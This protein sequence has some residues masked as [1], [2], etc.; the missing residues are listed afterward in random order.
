MSAKIN[1]TKRSE[2]GLMIRTIPLATVRL[3]A[4]S[5]PAFAADGAA[6]F[7]VALIPENWV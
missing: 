1:R 6:M 3:V 7:K 2:K 4:I 5:V